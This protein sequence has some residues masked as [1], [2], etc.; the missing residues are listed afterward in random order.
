M[1]KEV[2]RDGNEV[3]PKP[4][5][6]MCHSSE[7]V[8]EG[9]TCY[10][11]SGATPTNLVGNEVPGYVC[12][13]CGDTFIPDEK[14]NCQEPGDLKSNQEYQAAVTAVVETAEANPIESLP[15]DYEACGTCGFDHRYDG[16]YPEAHQ[17]IVS[18]HMGREVK[19]T[20]PIVEA[21]EALCLCGLDDSQ[22]CPRHGGG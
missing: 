20:F 7:H 16:A 8:Q 18:A 1:S 6:P 13:E 14:P 11:G 22:D 21:S 3:L 10:Q 19:L 5:C 4:A 12:R 2:D 17:K 15:A 9:M